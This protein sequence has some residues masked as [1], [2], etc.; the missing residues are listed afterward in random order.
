LIPTARRIDQPFSKI[1]N[2]KKSLLF[3]NTSVNEV[4]ILRNSV[5]RAC[6]HATKYLNNLDPKEME[7][8]VANPKKT[9]VHPGISVSK[10]IVLIIIHA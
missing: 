4:K 6:R 3:N 7:S 10:H 5:F 1:V 2:P 9:T 8:S